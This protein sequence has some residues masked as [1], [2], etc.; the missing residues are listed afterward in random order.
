MLRRRNIALIALAL[1]PALYFFAQQWQEGRVVKA[2]LSDAGLTNAPLSK[3]T[4]LQVA[5]AVRQD[6]NVDEDRF[7]SLDFSTQPFLRVSTRELLAHREGLCGEGSRVIVNLLLEL[8]FDATRVTLFDK[9]LE[10]SHTLVSVNLNGREFLVDSI[11]SKP[12]VN[13]LLARRDV[14]VRDFDVLH[15]SDDLIERRRAAKRAAANRA[16]PSPEMQSF[17]DDY[18]L[19]S[20]EAVPYAKLLTSAGLDVR[21]FNFQRPALLISHLA[22]KPD[23]VRGLIWLALAPLLFW[24]FHLTERRLRRSSPSAPPEPRQPPARRESAR[25]AHTS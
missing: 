19:Y 9:H 18:W 23:L 8:G 4:A 10:P 7:Q 25:E 14:S 11:N 22:E 17:F 20:F 24:A 1:L 5:D 6:F 13:A 16:A 15:Y 2:Y 12:E 21:A 3:Q